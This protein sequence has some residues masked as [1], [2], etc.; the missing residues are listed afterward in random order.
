MLKCLLYSYSMVPGFFIYSIY[1]PFENFGH[2]PSGVEKQ[3][4]ENSKSTFLEPADIGRL[5]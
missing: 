5:K 3:S 1:L 2:N 4:N